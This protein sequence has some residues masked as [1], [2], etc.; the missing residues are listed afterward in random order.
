M[1]GAGSMSVLPTLQVIYGMFKAPSLS[2]WVQYQRYIQDWTQSPTE[3]S[4]NE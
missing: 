4:G 1:T 2:T 3:L